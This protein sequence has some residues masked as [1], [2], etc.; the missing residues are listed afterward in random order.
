MAFVIDQ[1]SGT[2]TADNK[3]KKYMVKSRHTVQVQPVRY[4]LF[5]RESRP[6]LLTYGYL[7][8]LSRI[9]IVSKMLEMGNQTLCSLYEDGI[10]EIKIDAC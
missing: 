4:I 8:T 7:I 9:S 1:I 5:V 10:V 6:H 2:C 3:D